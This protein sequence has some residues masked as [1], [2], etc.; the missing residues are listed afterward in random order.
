MR[1]TLAVAVVLRA[2]L[3]APA[4]SRYGYEL[5]RLTGFGSGKLY[6]ILDRL[7]TA[8]W[9]SRQRESVDPAAAGRPQRVHYRLTPDGLRSARI[10]VATL[11]ERLRVP[12]G[13][14]GRLAPEAGV[15]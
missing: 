8:G 10:E 15:R 7:E 4:E 6:P 11:A 2:F 5:M 14:T 3:D 13:C 9:L 1:V 12:A